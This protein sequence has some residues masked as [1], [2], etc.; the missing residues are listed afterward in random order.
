MDKKIYI[1]QR[2]EADDCILVSDELLEYGDLEKANLGGVKSLK[3]V[4]V[5]DYD[6]NV[7]YYK[8]SKSDGIPF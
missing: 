7:E 4:Y 5:I 8:K 3:Q 6:D 2:Y 1:L